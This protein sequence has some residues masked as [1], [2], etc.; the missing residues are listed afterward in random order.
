MASP[1]YNVVSSCLLMENHISAGVLDSAEGF[2]AFATPAGNLVLLSIGSDAIFRASVEITGSQT[3]WTVTDISTLLANQYPAGTTL[4]AGYFASSE[5]GPDRHIS[6]LLSVT[7]KTN[8]SGNSVDEVWLLTGPS[9]TDASVWLQNGSISFTKLPYDA[10][11]SPPIHGITAATLKVTGLYAET[12]L[13]PT[14]PTLSLATVADPDAPGELRCFLLSP[15]ASTGATKWS[16]YAQEQDVGVGGLSIAPGRIRSDFYSWGLYKM[17]QLDGTPSLTYLP[18]EGTF[19]PPDATI[20]TVPS[21]ASTIATLVYQ[22]PGVTAS[23]TDLFVA[24]DGYIAYFPYN[25]GPPH[26]PIQLVISSLIVGVTQLHAVTCGDQAFIWGLNGAGQLFYTAAPLAERAMPSAWKSPLPLLGN[27]SDITAVTSSSDY[28]IDLFAVAPLSSTTAT[29]NS[30]VGNGLVRLSRNASTGAWLNSVHPM[31]T[32]MDCITIKTYTTHCLVEDSNNIPQPLVALT[33]TASADCSLIINGSAQPVFAGETFDMITDYS[34][35][36]NIIHAVSSLATPSFVLTLVGGETFNIDPSG[37]VTTALS[38]ITS[39]DLANATYVDANGQTQ[40]LV[41]AGTSAEAVSGVTQGLQTIS[42]HL[43]KLPRVAAFNARAKQVKLQSQDNDVLSD[44]GDIVQWIIN[45]VDD[46]AEM[47]FEVVGDVI[48]FV[49]TIGES[50]IKA[51]IKT[52]EDAL[53]AITALFKWIGAEVEA[54]FRWLAFVFNWSDFVTV[55]NLLKDIVNQA[56]TSFI[57]IENQVKVAGDDWF[58]K[59]KADII[60]NLTSTKMAKPGDV[61]VQEAWSSHQPP[62]PPIG[63]HQVDLRSD[64]RVGWLKSRM[65]ADPTTTTHATKSNNMTNIDPVLEALNTLMQDVGKAFV[66]VF[67]DIQNLLDGKV[68]A[69]GFF[70]AILEAAEL[71][72]LDALQAVFDS[73]MSIMGTVVSLIQEGLNMHLEIPIVSPLYRLATG[74]DLTLLDLACFLGGIAINVIYKIAYD[75]SPVEVMPQVMSPATVAQDITTML[76]PTASSALVVDGVDDTLGAKNAIAGILFILEGLT[77]PINTYYRFKKKYGP[78]NVFY[79]VCMVTRTLRVLLNYSIAK[80]RGLYRDWRVWES[81]FTILWTTILLL[82][83][84]L[85]YENPDA[86][87]IWFG[88]GFTSMIVGIWQDIAFGQRKMKCYL[89]VACDSFCNELKMVDVITVV[90]KMPYQAKFALGT[91]FASIFNGDLYFNIIR[92]MRA[93]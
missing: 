51:V 66:T 59:V 88:D 61:S 11:P 8:G 37:Q 50:V 12:G 19:G 27:V 57:S 49:V 36:V 14:D 46:V 23:Y 35:Y 26:E 83:L 40:N 54:V 20:F 13:L 39:S 10:I 73:F 24:A 74:N 86:D 56:I 1:T 77:L 71:L 70:D 41:A 30:A 34:G 4:S 44:L 69:L 72:G 92:I 18:T 28:A 76:S 3:G 33:A 62:P 9:A 5:S 67:S 17:Y 42:T 85:S 47:V 7:A 32:T 21:G 48:H 52:V 43:P 78:A 53:N 75:Q 84:G 29:S 90:L 2:T 6:I 55:K 64:P 81:A 25:Q 38:N 79:S 65:E 60:P 16:Y 87:L 15:T 22:P 63:P 68:S 93:I 45:V 58:S 89:S 31:P 82:V 91:D 80:E